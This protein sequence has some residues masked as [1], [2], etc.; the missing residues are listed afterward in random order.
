[1]VSLAKQEEKNTTIF[2]DLD[3]GFFSLT[4]VYLDEPIVAGA[5]LHKEYPNY[6]DDWIPCV[7]ENLRSAKSLY[8]YYVAHQQ[9]REENALL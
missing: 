7:E 4:S 5:I 1:M 6:D 2:L 8:G 9:E 3:D